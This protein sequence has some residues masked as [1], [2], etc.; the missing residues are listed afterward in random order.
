MLGQRQVTGP[1]FLWS[2]CLDMA[3]VHL[4]FKKELC[5]QDRGLW[6]G[7]NGMLLEVHRIHGGWLRQCRHLLNTEACGEKNE[8][9]SATGSAEGLTC[10]KSQE[11]HRSLEQ[12]SGQFAEL[13][14]QLRDTG[15]KIFTWET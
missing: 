12:M 7:A 14:I 15:R 3:W 5:L 11:S 13:F 6:R 4:H 9:D 10:W 2:F 8:S 1:V